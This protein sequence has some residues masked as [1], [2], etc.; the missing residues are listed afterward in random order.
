M[1]QVPDDGFYTKVAIYIAG[2]ILGLAAKLANLNKQKNMT[3]R[4]FLARGLTAFACSW[5]VWQTLEHYNNLK[6][7]AMLSVFVGR[8][9]DEVIVLMWKGIRDAVNKFQP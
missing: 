4:E 9:A 5:A 3:K 2:T 8:Y 6:L 7:A 1:A